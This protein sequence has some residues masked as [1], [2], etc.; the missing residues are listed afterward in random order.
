MKNFPLHILLVLALILFSVDSFSVPATPYPIKFIQPD[1]T[2]L[3]IR[4]R[5][6]EFFNYETTLDGY[7]IRKDDTGFYKYATVD[8][9]NNIKATQVRVNPIEK[10]TAEE[11]E[12][13]KQLLPNPDF[14]TI[15]ESKKAARI[16]SSDQSSEMQKI[17]PTTGSPKSIVILVNFSDVSFVTSDPKTAF[18]NLLNEEGYSANNGTGS[19]R[20]YFRD[21]SNGA[22][23]PE[24]V[25]V[26]PYN[27]PNPRSYY[28]G[29][30]DND[31]DVR[32]RQMV[33]DACNAANA[34]VDFTTYD[35]DNDGIVDNVFIYYAGHNEA[36]G[37]PDES[38]WPHRWVL[39]T[40]LQLD[41]KYISGY[42]CTSEL[43][44]SSGSY[45]CGI[46]TFVHEFGHVYG[47]PDFYATDGS[48]HHTLS[49]WDVM[50]A[51]PYLNLGRTPPTYSAYERF[52]L[53]WL[54][55][56]ILN[57]S[58][59]VILPD[60]ISSN[61]AYLISESGTHNLRGNNPSP[62][63]FF[64][65]E[66]RQP[67][68][69]DAYLPGK[70][71][72][73]TRVY[74]NS[75][76]WRNNSPNNNPDAMGVDIMEADGN[77]SRSNLS[78]DPFPGNNNITSYSP[79]LR[80]GTNIG[81]PLSSIKEVDG[82]ISFL[83]MGGGAPSKMFSDFNGLTQF[84]TIFGTPSSTQKFGISGFNLRS[85]V[86]VSFASGSHFELKLEDNPVDEWTKSLSLAITD[87]VL[88]SVSVLIRY[89]PIEASYS[90]THLDYVRISSESADQLQ[91][92]VTATSARPVYVVSPVANTPE[93]VSLNGYMASWNAVY[94]ATGY[95]LTA[96][97]V[98]E[99][100][101]SF[102][103]GF[104]K[105]LTAP[106]GWTINAS[107]TSQ[108]ATYAGDSIPSILLKKTGESIETEEYI[109][110]VSNLS[111]FVRSIG[112][113]SGTLSVDGWNGVN[114]LLIEDIAVNSNLNTTKSYDFNTEQGYLRFRLRYNKGTDNSFD[115]VLVSI[116][117][118][119]V[120]LSHKLEFNAKEKWVKG[121][122]DYISTVIPGREYF[123][124][125][126]ASDRTLNTN[127]TLK[128]ENFT[129]FS[130][131]VQVS[132]NSE[133][134]IQ[135]ANKTG[136]VSVYRDVSGEVLLNLNEYTD[137]DNLIYIYST[138]GVL[139][140]TIEVSQSTVSLA[141]LPKN[142]IYFARI[143]VHSLKILL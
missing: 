43:R 23:S 21:A 77:A 133:G 127:N 128:Y 138:D 142:N 143:G 83:F 10:R 25:V 135:F 73:I 115:N 136:T 54:S 126:R 76:T 63:E 17:Y 122:S 2:E 27:L 98:T 67:T 93:D 121:T 69:W 104:D 41:G 59:D 36:E 118:I 90:D 68:G 61:K 123:F 96:Y 106:V 132:L 45:M 89:N 110:A 81:Q 120:T 112:D 100:T 94:D 46:G 105:G 7:L 57:T 26:G 79:V 131:T 125:V 12:F 15:Q 140:E 92:M 80:S 31:D 56:N 139:I 87:S 24:F 33:I 102:K 32:P 39:S 16:A 40:P 38:V 71:L 60:L 44:S 1:G 19:A 11:N 51:G 141:H 13:I 137:E 20:D 42:A 129:D 78:G 64:L 8:N 47:L 30:N 48:E 109:L 34:D 3:T 130:N 108:S 22:S 5:G 55:P 14:R 103:E 37:G 91:M 53:G 50:D 88:D 65:L 28:G 84:E 95:Y 6:D 97:N 58:S 101:S 75:T 62:Q 9:N 119:E 116:D 66:N 99:G 114:W 85:D 4:L 72:L 29:N 134:V 70:G 86:T 107:S 117:D 82:V 49:F 35:T 124:K 113:N 111:F 18:H 74:Y 52:F